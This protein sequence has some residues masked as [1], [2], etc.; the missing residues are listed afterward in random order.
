MDSRLGFIMILVHYSKTLRTSTVLAQKSHGDNGAE[1]SRIRREIDSL[2]LSKIEIERRISELESQLHEIEGDGQSRG[3]PFVGGA[4]G[5]GDYMPFSVEILDNVKIP[6]ER[7]YCIQFG[8]LSHECLQWQLALNRNL[9]AGCSR[10]A[11]WHAHNYLV[12]LE[13]FMCQP[14]E[15]T[16]GRQPMVTLPWDSGAA[17]PRPDKQHVARSWWHVTLPCP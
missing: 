6:S 9:S 12:T 17:L 8:D 16:C 5:G 15:M 3:F 11:M 4:S 2:Q 14:R 1:A 13:R 7:D 10:S